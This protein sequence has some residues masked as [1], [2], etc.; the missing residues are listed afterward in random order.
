MRIFQKSGGSEV[1]IGLHGYG[2]SGEAF[3]SR[4][5][6]HWPEATFIAPDLPFH[7]ATHWPQ[8]SFS[9][10]ALSR[11]LQ[12]L[13]DQVGAE[14]FILIGHSFGA[15]LALCSLPFLAG[16]VAR[17]VLLAPD[18]LETKGMAWP[19]LLPASLG[20]LLL[21]WPNGLLS[22]GRWFYRRRLL[23]ATAWIFLQ[24]NLR[25]PLHR[26]RLL[27][28]WQSLPHFHCS[29]QQARELIRQSGIP[30]RIMMGARDPVLRIDRLSA[31]LKQWPEVD[32]VVTPGGHWVFD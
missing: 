13:A 3:L 6:A 20:R 17:L 23:P 30:V 4:F 21:S 24:R 31:M 7:G 2:E 32:V 8:S 16:R 18:G 22:L 5:G 12:S 11:V 19:F 15:R 27:H 10:K 14:R 1:V 9:A 28:T 29:P 25:S 26:K